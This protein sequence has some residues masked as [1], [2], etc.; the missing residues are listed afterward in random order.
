MTSTSVFS[1]MIS[2]D[3]IDNGHFLFEIE[4]KNVVFVRFPF[5]RWSQREHGWQ[6]HCR[7]K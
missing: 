1:F 2:I 6:W 4:S 7:M 5:N 3:C